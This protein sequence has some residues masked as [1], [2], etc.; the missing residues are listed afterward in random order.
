MK[1]IYTILIVLAFLG[2]NGMAQTAYISNYSDGTVSVINVAN[3]AL[4]PPYMLVP[5]L[6]VYL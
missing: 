1:K 5:V 4:L 6:L 3:D 2:M